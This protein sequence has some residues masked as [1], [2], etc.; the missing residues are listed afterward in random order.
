LRLLATAAVIVV[1]GCTTATGD[2]AKSPR[3]KSTSASSTTVAPT[4]TTTPSIAYQVKRG[5]T[6][7]SIAKFFGVSSAT[8]AAANQLA[9]GDRLT[10]GQVLQIPPT[11][12]PQVTVTPPDAVAG[13]V[14]TFTVA[15]AKAGEVVTFEIVTP[16][17]GIFTGQPHTASQD[18]TVTTT[19]HSSGDAPGTY[20][21]V[22]TGDRGTSVETTYRLLG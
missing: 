17:G 13:T 8:I 2:N 12:P 14:F 9:N 11:P 1:A 5:D 22:A 7:T 6:L 16:S 15:S 4:T 19:Y 18:G 21:V 10:E 3:S 20:K